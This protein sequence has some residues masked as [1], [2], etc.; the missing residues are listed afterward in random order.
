MSA[1]RYLW[2]HRYGR[3][4]LLTIAATA[5]LLVAG[6]LSAILGP[7]LGFQPGFP[8][9]FG[10]PP[11]LLLAL[12][13]RTLPASYRARHRRLACGNHRMVRGKARR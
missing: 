5:L 4:A 13:P 8:P 10:W 6:A 2:N 3:L 1:A 9:A 7:R 12:L 11:Y